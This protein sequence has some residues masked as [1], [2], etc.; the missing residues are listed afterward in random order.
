MAR[1]TR[2]SEVVVV[3]FAM[4]ALAVIVAFALTGTEEPVSV[5]PAQIPDMTPGP[6]RAPL[7]GLVVD[8]VAALDHPAVAIK[9]SDVRQAH[10]QTGVDRADIVFVEPIGVSYT[11]LAAVFH[12][13]IPQTVGPVR[14]I[15]P[16]DAPLLGPLAPVFGNTMG[17]RWVVDYV[18]ATAN[19]D[20]LGTLRVSGSGAYV[21]DGTRPRPDDVFA[22]P[23][24]LLDLSDFTA[25]PDPYFSYTSDTEPSSAERAGGPGT[26]AEVPYGPGWSVTW[27]YDDTAGRYLRQQPWGPHVTTEGT[28]VGAVNVLI[29]QVGSETRKIGAG[30]GAPVPVLDLIDASGEFVAL[31]GGRS[32]TGTWSKAG[33]DEPFQLRT[34]DAENL[35]LSPGNTWVELS[36]P[37]ADVTL[38]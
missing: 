21:Q 8:D 34:D 27:T 13:D 23:L 16:P 29:L 31:A 33:V 2:R 22:K 19:V 28:Q 10:P 38:H 37:S 5:P 26:S 36:A 9:V 35:L 7:T 32:V 11:R 6:S 1:G 12:S 17:A 14:S 20:D 4:V 18:D 30:S 24:V 15:R 25:A 3:L